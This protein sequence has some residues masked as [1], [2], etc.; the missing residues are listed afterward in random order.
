MGYVMLE[1]LSSRTNCTCDL[2]KIWCELK[3]NF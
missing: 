3:D 1:R 2:L